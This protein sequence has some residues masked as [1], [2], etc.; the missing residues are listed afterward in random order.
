MIK[1]TAGILLLTGVALCLLQVWLPQYYLTG[2]GPSHVYNAQVLHDLWAGKNTT[3]YSRFYRLV[4]EPNPN[5]L[6][7]AAIAALMNLVN[8]IAAEK[9]FL[10]V[11]IV[12]YV[13]GFYLLLKKISNN[14]SFLLLVILVFVFPQTLAKGFYNFSF[15]I[16]FYFWVVWSW[17]RFLE[18]RTIGNALLFFLFTSLIFFTHLLAFGFAA[19]TCAA[20]IVSWGIAAARENRSQKFSV[21]FFKNTSFLVLF[22]SPFLMLMNWFTGKEGGMRLT[23]KPHLY[24]LIELVEGK[25]LVNVTHAEDFLAE[26]AGIIML[27]LFCFSFFG[28]KN[29]WKINKYD[30]FLLSLVFVMFVYLCFPE[31]FLGRLILISM[32][33]Q[34]FV[35]I[36]MVCCIAYR[37]P[38]EKLKVSGAFIILFIFLVFSIAEAACLRSAKPGALASTYSLA[39]MTGVSVIMLLTVFILILCG[40]L[41]RLPFTKIRNAG[42]VLLFACFIALACV[43]LYCLLEAAP[44][45]ADYTSAKKFIRPYSVVLPLDFAPCGKN[46]QGQIISDRN[47]L[48]YH[49]SQYMGIEKP[50]IILDNYEANMG[51]FPLRWTDNTNPYYHLSKEEGIEAQPPYAG[52]E[53]YKQTTGVNIDYILMWCFDSSYLANEHFRKLYTE[54][55]AGYHVVY[56]SPARRTV[57]LEQNH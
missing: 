32:R 27:A 15:S 28:I 14:T 3:F 49:A 42:F 12:L 22:L 54:I 23:L 2:D 33:A 56:T 48:F 8:G 13:S 35:Y 45:V 34:L 19:F 41:L 20:L 17:L 24:R 37:P 21:F 38:A 18:R 10:T 16:A 29:K 25:Y 30:G 5:W 7:T 43:R 55:N 51:Y 31:S 47:F 53:A 4:Y 26:L 50:M 44:A 46:K 9:I 11:Y 57:L 52:I 6:S 39:Q 1:K 40:A 36:L